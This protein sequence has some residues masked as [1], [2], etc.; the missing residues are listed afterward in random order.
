MLGVMK[1]AKLWA[2]LE[3]A[4]YELINKLED[5]HD[6]LVRKSFE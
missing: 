3:I 5:L 4:V 2:M 1:L 6:W